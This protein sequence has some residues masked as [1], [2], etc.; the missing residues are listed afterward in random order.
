[1]KQSWFE[2]H[3]AI[4]I[5]LIIIGAIVLTS[6]IIVAIMPK[7]NSRNLQ[8]SNANDLNPN[9]QN[10]TTPQQTP[11]SQDSGYLE[12]TSNTDCSSNE[13]CKDN[14][15]VKIIKTIV[16][17]HSRSKPA[18][19]NTPLSIHFGYEWGQQVD[20][21]ITL[22]NIKRGESAWSA[23]KEANMFN[24]EP[25]EGK[26]YLLAKFRFKLVK[27]S[28]DKSYSL[29]GYS[30]DTVSGQGLVYEKLFAVAPEPSLDKEIYPG[31]SHEGWV[32]FKIDK[33]D[34]TPLIS[35]NREGG[36]DDELW[37]NLG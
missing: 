12:C 28:D 36:G 30:F 26:E 10:T 4:G 7:E 37:F 14:K 27:T 2:K 29:S 8:N 21:E 25:E 31:A 9:Q 3:K 33:S 24:D 6:I 15:C 1:M 35:F 16:L 13:E 23:I 5:I 18:P 11:P 19:I 17:G 32:V 20:A 22:L 34:A